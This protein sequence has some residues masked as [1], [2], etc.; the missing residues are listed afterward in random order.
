MSDEVASR[1]VS[2]RTLRIRIMTRMEAM[3][4]DG[5]RC[6]NQELQA[7]IADTVRLARTHGRRLTDRGDPI[8]PDFAEP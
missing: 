7:N 4:N 1:F 2:L 8:Y 3:R 5:M 6:D